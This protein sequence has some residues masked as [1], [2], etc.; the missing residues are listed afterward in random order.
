M[1]RH[2]HR[3]TLSAV[4]IAGLSLLALPDRAAAACEDEAKF[5]SEE[6]ILNKADWP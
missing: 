3:C 6:Y 1:N 2:F 5:L 4:A